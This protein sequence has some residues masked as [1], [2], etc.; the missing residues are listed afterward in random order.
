MAVVLS[1]EL[2]RRESAEAIIG[3]GQP[4]AAFGVLAFVDDVQAG[5]A[6]ALDELSNGGFSGQALGCR[7]AA[8]MRGQNFVRA[9]LHARLYERGTPALGAL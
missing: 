6:L 3:V 5:L 9:P 2:A 4:V 7:Q 1:L 8:Y